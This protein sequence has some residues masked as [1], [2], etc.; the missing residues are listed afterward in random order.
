MKFPRTHIESQD[1]FPDEEYCWA[2]LRRARW[3]RGFVCPRCGGRC[4]HFLAS[5]TSSCARGPTWPSPHSLTTI[6]EEPPWNL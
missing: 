5:G 2:Y 4:S 6:Y 1:Q 3:P